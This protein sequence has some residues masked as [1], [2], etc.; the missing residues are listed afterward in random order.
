MSARRPTARA[1]AVL[2]DADHAGL[3]QAAVDGDAPIGQ[4][5]GDHVGGAVLLEAQFRV[6]VDVASDGRDG[7]HIGQDGFDEVHGGG[8]RE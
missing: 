1:S 3:A 6:G 8:R 7:G 2:H 5:L 4:R